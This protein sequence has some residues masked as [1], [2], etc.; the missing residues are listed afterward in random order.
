MVETVVDLVVQVED[1]LQ[2]R[3]GEMRALK[4]TVLMLLLK[5]TVN[6]IKEKVDF[7]C[8]YYFRIRLNNKCVSGN[9]SNLILIL[10]LGRKSKRKSF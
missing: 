1:A 5:L 7:E 8:H 10:V 9:F 3:N 4:N 6:G 2:L